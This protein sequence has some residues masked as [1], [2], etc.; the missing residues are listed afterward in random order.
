M[1][2]E[3]LE[4]LGRSL[5][6][7]HDWSRPVIT[8]T[9]TTGCLALYV[10]K[11]GLYPGSFNPWHEGHTDILN[12]ALKVFDFVTVLHCYNPDKIELTKKGGHL[13]TVEEVL[14]YKI[15]D[16]FKQIRV[17][18]HPG[19]LVDYI[20]S[21]PADALIRGLR[22]SQDFEYEKVQQYW[23][24]DLG[25]AIPTIYF[26]ADR[27]LVHMSSSAIRMLEKFTSKVK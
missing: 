26:V 14:K 7:R 18:S 23:N 22:N 10:M 13:L 8:R 20:K 27:K 24:E 6:L 1:A 9:N 11:H 17:D 4:V 21:Y 16:M 25:L 12:K 3:E 15:T 2:Q 5:V 19:L